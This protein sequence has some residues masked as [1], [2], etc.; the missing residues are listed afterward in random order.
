MCPKCGH[1]QK[2]KAPDDLFMCG[3]C[4]NFVDGKEVEDEQ[5]TR[6]RDATDS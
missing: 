4:L 6:K 2:T 3:V 1:V 5:V